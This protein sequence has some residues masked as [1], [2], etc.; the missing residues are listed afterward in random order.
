M[1]STKFKN[2]LLAFIIMNSTVLLF[3]AAPIQTASLG[4][5]SA[6]SAR[7]R[8]ITAAQAYLG[9]VYRYGGMDLSGIDCSGLIYASFRDALRITVPRTTAALYSWAEKIPA[10][11]MEPGDLVF[12]ITTGP[13][14]SHVGIYIG[15]GTFIHAPSEGNRTGVLYSSLDDSYWRRTFAGAGRALPYDESLQ[16]AN[17]P[18]LNPAG[19]SDW[20]GSKGLFFGFGM[21]AGA[22][23]FV[24]G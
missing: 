2:I 4:S 18:G 11:E 9:T 24:D 23:G 16:E 10:G 8:L 7:S 17:T 13:G 22:G 3:P 21:T 15:K 5:M 1:K 12:F 14:I 19:L 6:G 20:T